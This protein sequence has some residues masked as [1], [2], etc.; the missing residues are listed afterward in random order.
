MRS[1]STCESSSMPINFSPRRMQDLR[2]GSPS[3]IS[4]P[5]QHHEKHPGTGLQTLQLS[6]G[7]RIII[8]AFFLPYCST[9]LMVRGAGVSNGLACSCVLRMFFHSMYYYRPQSMPGFFQ[10][11]FCRGIMPSVHS[12]WSTCRLQ[13]DDVAHV[14]SAV[15]IHGSICLS[16]KSNSSHQLLPPLP[17]QFKILLTISLIRTSL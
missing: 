17:W 14:P 11:I 16:R 3:S 4:Q 1:R 9:F 2:P 15:H 6:F 7:P 10:E 13:C 12:S 5:F 8:Q